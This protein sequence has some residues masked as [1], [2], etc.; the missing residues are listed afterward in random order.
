M[1][2]HQVQESTVFKNSSHESLAKWKRD[3]SAS[4]LQV[5][6]KKGICRF[7]SKHC[8]KVQYCIFV[9]LFSCG[10]GVFFVVGGL[11]CLFIFGF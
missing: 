5:K 2:D 6:K 1:L 9:L 7:L 4:A 3:F 11:V 10:I 8:F